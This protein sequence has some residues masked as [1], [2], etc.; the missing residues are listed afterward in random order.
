MKF[1][2]KLNATNMNLDYNLTSSL[3]PHSILKSTTTIPSLK[4]INVQ[5]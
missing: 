4:W 2:C 1:K 3:N 5:S